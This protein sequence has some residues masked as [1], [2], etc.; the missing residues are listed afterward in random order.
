MWESADGR[1][2]ILLLNIWLLLCCHPPFL[3]LPVCLHLCFYPQ[4]EIMQFWKPVSPLMN[5]QFSPA[6]DVSFIIQASSC[7]KASFLF[8]RTMSQTV[9]SSLLSN[10]MDLLILQSSVDAQRSLVIT[11]IAS[12]GLRSHDTAE[13]RL[14]PSLRS[15]ARIS[16][17]QNLV[18]TFPIH[19]HT[20]VEM[21]F[22]LWER[23]STGCCHS[24]YWE[25]GFARSRSSDDKLPHVRKWEQYLLL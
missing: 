22:V 6:F 12:D 16:A 19:T 8:S 13:K 11:E 4:E 10:Q 15:S 3:C 5:Q 25:T 1:R 23:I 2:Y 21:L 24:H 14:P 9:F 20:C 18:I 17:G 7:L